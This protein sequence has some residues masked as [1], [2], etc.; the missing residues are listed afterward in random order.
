MTDV[1]GGGKGQKTVVGGDV[2]VNIGAKSGEGALS[3]SGTVNGSVYG[4]SALGVVNATS[5]K[6]DKGDITAYTPTENKTA[7]VNIYGGTVNGSVFG[8]GLGEKTGSSDIAAQNFGDAEISMEGGSVGDAIYGGANANGVLKAD[9]EVT[10]LGGTIGTSWTTP[11]PDPLPDVVFGGGKGEPTLVNGSVLVN[12]GNSTHTGTAAIY[13]NVYG[14]SALGN[15]NASKTGNDP[16]EFY[17]DGETAK[18]TYVNLYAGTINGNV[19]GGGLGRKAAAAVGTEGQEGYVA[20]VEAVESFVG[21][22]VTVTLDGAKLVNSFSGEGVDYKP[23]TGQIF[24]ANNLNGTPK[25]HVKVH[26]KRTV[27]SEKPTGTA[28]DNRNT[29]DVAAVYGGGNQADYHPTKADGTDD[30]KKDAFAEVLIEGCD[31]TSIEYVYG[32]GNAA[33]V[34]ATEVTILGSYIIDYVFGGGNGKGTGNPGANVGSYDNGTSEY[35]TGKAVTKLVG[36]HI[37]YVFGGSNTKGNVRGGTSISM[38]DKTSYVEE[39]YNC[40]NVRDIKEIY[41]AGNE[42]EQDGA[43]T[44]I[45]GCVDNMDYV[46]G[47]ARKANVKGGVDLVVTSGHF[48]GVFGGNDQSGTIQGP[49]TLT[50]EETG[51]DP[52][53]IDNLYLGGNQA[54]YSVYGYKN[55]GTEDNPVLVARKEAEYNALTAEQKTA[56]GLPYDHPVLNVVSCTSIGNIFGGGYGSDATMYG[57]P[58]VNVNMIPGKFAK[59]IDRD[60]DYPA[61]SDATALGIIGNVYGGGE[62]ARV[63]G[64]TAVNIC[65]ASTVTVRSDNGAPVTNDP[66]PVQGA[67]ITDNVFGAGKGLA[68]NVNSALVTGNTTI[69]MVKGSVAKSVYGGGQLSQ[70]GGDTNITISGGTIGKDRVETATPGTYTYYGGAT[71][72]NVYGGGLGSESGVGFGLVKGNTDIIITDGTV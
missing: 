28:R 24:G 3:G 7:K 31:E 55:T 27:D 65:T 17:T 20:P 42:A 50:I 61:H 21:G 2:I 72:G 68:D 10:L 66:T 64:S 48:K 30:E 46:F 67:L 11:A 16:M 33:A 56:E 53:V 58:T 23:V 26:V 70:V 12:V 34:P 32:G 25:G 4:G 9:A 36:G 47:G 8:G 45:L 49:I 22:D 13:G 1:Y 37:M 29:Y 69:V 51:C 52:L 6:D 41:G 19:F 60:G 59:D 54:A 57:S 18:K 14:G 38:P 35:G 40:C 15:T 71:Y 5:T 39:G 43:V 63:E 62:E 44:M